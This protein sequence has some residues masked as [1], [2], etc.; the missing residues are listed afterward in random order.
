M[1]S[2]SGSQ[3]RNGVVM[4][5]R[6]SVAISLWNEESLARRRKNRS[7]NPTD[8]VNNVSER[9]YYPACLPPCVRMIWYRLP[10]KVK[11]TTR[12]QGGDQDQRN[13]QRI[14]NTCAKYADRRE[15]ETASFSD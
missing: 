2:H 11:F 14:V 6:F 10:E 3:I 7:R 8:S 4:S 9:Y 5:L 15:A 12:P 1:L 13:E